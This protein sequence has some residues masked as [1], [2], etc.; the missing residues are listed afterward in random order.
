MSLLLLF[1][2]QVPAP[3]ATLAVRARG[4]TVSRP[5]RSLTVGAR[6]RTVAVAVVA[7]AVEGVAQP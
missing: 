3:L 2:G 5:G 4:L 1:N 6:G 7:R